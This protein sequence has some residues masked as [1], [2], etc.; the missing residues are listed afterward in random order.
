MTQPRK[1]PILAEVLKLVNQLS[2]DELLEL[3]LQLDAT[4]LT[5]SNVDL[6]NPAE[7]AAFFKQEEARAGRRVKQAFEK[8]Q[9]QGIL[10]KKGKL[11][12]SGLPA[13]MEPGS[14]C[15]VGG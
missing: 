12:K 4:S 13:D 1:R 9:G 7:R 14:E 5:W 2:A 6:R 15:D 10:D 11:T 8:L 3:R